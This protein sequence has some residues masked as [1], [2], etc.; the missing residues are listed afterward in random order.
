MIETDALALPPCQAHP[1]QTEHGLELLGWGCGPKVEPGQ[2]DTRP[3]PELQTRSSQGFLV[4]PY[5]PSQHV[6][7]AEGQEGVQSLG[8]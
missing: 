1:P 7:L 3:Q 6:L 8:A 4:P 2:A 5:P